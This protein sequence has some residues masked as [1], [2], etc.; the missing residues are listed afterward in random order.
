[1]EG[2]LEESDPFF[3]IVDQIVLERERHS[4]RIRRSRRN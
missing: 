3:D 1:V 2:W 4:P